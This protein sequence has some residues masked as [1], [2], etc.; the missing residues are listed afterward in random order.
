MKVRGTA[1]ELLKK[2]FGESYNHTDTSTSSSTKSLYRDLK[3]DR[4]SNNNGVLLVSFFGV[5]QKERRSK[6]VFFQVQ[7]K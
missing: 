4:A 7:K 6:F 3:P 1:E 5:Y 2:L